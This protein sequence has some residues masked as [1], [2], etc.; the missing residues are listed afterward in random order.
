MRFTERLELAKTCVKL[1]YIKENGAVYNAILNGN[2]DVIRL[3]QDLL[4]FDRLIKKN[5][6]NKPDWF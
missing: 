4:S 5:Q 3:Y 6:T 1:E 2:S